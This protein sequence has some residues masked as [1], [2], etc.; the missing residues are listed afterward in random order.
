MLFIK[1]SLVHTEN[2]M[3]QDLSEQGYLLFIES[4]VDVEKI[5]DKVLTRITNTNDEIICD[6]KLLTYMRQLAYF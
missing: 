5:S 2:L 1:N 4:L 6:K 3:I